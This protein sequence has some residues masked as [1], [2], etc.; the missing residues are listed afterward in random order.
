MKME[1]VFVKV[2]MHL[3]M[4]LIQRIK[5]IHYITENFINILLNNRFRIDTPHV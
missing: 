1:N 5:L 2:I 3:F 4:N